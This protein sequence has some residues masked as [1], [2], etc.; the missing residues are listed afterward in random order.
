V[1]GVTQDHRQCHQSKELI[2]LPIRL[3]AYFKKILKTHKHGECRSASLLG[4]GIVSP[5]GSRTRAQ[6]DEA[7][8]ILKI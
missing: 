6:G 5:A 7:E 4:S 8:G 1:I 3:D 2:P